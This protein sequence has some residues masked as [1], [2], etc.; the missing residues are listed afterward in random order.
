MANQ[1]LGKTL[2]REF[3]RTVK[4]IQK[5]FRK[6]FYDGYGLDAGSY[7]AS[8]EQALFN[9][10]ANMIAQDAP[11]QELWANRAQN[12]IEELR[13]DFE[14]EFPGLFNQVQFV[15]EV[16]DYDDIDPDDGSTATSEY[17]YVGGRE[18][19]VLTKQDVEYFKALGYKRRSTISPTESDLE[20][21]ID[22]VPYIVGIEPVYR[23]GEFEGYVV[24]I[25]YN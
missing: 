15:E 19:P 17:I 21:Y 1:G 6:G 22:G 12:L 14:D 4:A 8:M 18:L 24:W 2:F 10:N 5:S 7:E 13:Q 16:S 20:G 11:N 25:E 3:S 23:N 9:Y